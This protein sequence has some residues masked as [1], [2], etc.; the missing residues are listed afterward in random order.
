VLGTLSR[1]SGG[2]VLGTLS[3]EPRGEVLLIPGLS[4]GPQE[5]RSLIY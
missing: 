4:V 5:G 2:E 1:T 3:G